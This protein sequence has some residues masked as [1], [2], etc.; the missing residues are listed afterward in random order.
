MQRG[1]EPV[2]ADGKHI[3][4]TGAGSQGSGTPTS[5]FR[6][7][8]CSHIV[9]AGPGQWNRGLV[10]SAL[11]RTVIRFPVHGGLLPNFDDEAAGRRIF[12]SNPSSRAQ[13]LHMV[14]LIDSSPSCTWYICYMRKRSYDLTAPCLN[15]GLQ[16][17]DD[18]VGAANGVAKRSQRGV[19]AESCLDHAVA[20]GSFAQVIAWMEGISDIPPT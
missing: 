9:A 16:L 20:Y 13:S 12:G 1:L 18:A 11:L 6:S 8:G 19:G 3:L 10:Q 17:L 14:I 15:L 7:Y 4:Y 5:A 2:P